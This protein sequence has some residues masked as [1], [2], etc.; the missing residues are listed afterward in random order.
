MTRLSNDTVAHLRDL[1]EAPDLGGTRYAIVREIARGGMG[2][3]YEAD[4]RELQR[5]VALKVLALEGS[6]PAAQ[7]R[8]LEEARTI[9]RLE[10]P[11]IV[12]VHDAGALPDGRAW[13]AMKLVQGVTL[14][15][16][17]AGE[18]ST[19]DLLRIFL[20]VCETAAFA[21]AHGFVHRDIKPDNV[22]IGSFG[23]VF[24][25]DWGVARPAG[26]T[27]GAEIAGTHGYMPPEQERGEEVDASAD[28]YALGVML[29]A[30][31]AQPARPLRAIIAMA[32]NSDRSQRYKD[33]GA[34]A[35]DLVHFLDGE[36]VAAYR[37]GIIGALARLISKHRALV[38]LVAA[39]LVMRAI[40]LL[41]GR[42]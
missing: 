1:T 30:M 42:V 21:H 22:M 4:D 34:L 28:V 36:R 39:Y 29:E 2:V 11:G 31:S 18:R 12:P 26:M 27:G 25:M 24:V 23:E 38:G 37:E 35:A 16:Y 33:A 15:E 41:W 5:R 9:A 13:Y 3:I 32:R 7:T 10:H 6:S 17:A 19:A 8:M 14:R 40:I 20:R